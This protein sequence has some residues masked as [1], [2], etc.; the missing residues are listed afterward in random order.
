MAVVGVAVTVVTNCWVSAVD[1][2]SVDTAMVAAAIGRDVVA[3]SVVNWELV[4]GCC[5]DVTPK[6]VVNLVE[7]CCT[8]VSDALVDVTKSVVRLDVDV[9]AGV[10]VISCVEGDK[11][12]YEV[13]IA[14]DVACSD[15]VSRGNVVIDEVINV[16]AA[17]IAGKIGTTYKNLTAL[18]YRS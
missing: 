9:A 8:V 14:C 18:L 6:P 16:D 1:M 10:V 13:V 12:L 3:C 11:L 5:I 7:G 4:D 17:V 15:V 2:M